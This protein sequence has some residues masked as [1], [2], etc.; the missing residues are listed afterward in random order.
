[1]LYLRKDPLPRTHLQGFHFLIQF[2]SLE[3]GLHPS[4][5]NQPEHQ[6]RL[7]NGESE[8]VRITSAEVVQN[9]YDWPPLKTTPIE[10][11]IGVSVTSKQLNWKSEFRFVPRN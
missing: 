11:E 7:I 6:E 10:R 4:N 3:E 8:L 9:V 2:K 5:Y 1:M